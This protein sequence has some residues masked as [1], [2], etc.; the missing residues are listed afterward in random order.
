MRT[1]PPVIGL[2]V[3]GANT[4]AAVVDG[5]K[6][7]RI[8]SEPY[9]VW[10]DPEAMSGVIEDVVGRFGLDA[11]PVALTTT[12]EL[13]DVFASKREGVLHVLG[14]AER[15]L[16]GRRL[17]VMSTG[18]ELIAMEAA[19]AAPLA[20]AAANWMATALLVARSLPEAILVDCGG[21]T[22][23]VIPIA[24]GEVAARAH[25]DLERLLEGE[26]VYT[27]ALRTN[28]AAVLAQVP[29]GGRS[30]PVSSELFAVTAD[31]HLLRG[32]LTPEQCTCSF[33]DGRG[34]STDEV[35][36]RL[37]R[38]VCADPEQLGDRDLETI[39]AAVE[40]AQVD[41]IAAAL[42]RVAE[43]RQGEAA[44]VLAVGIGAF[45]ARAAAARC[46]LSVHEE[47][48]LPLAG[49]AGD[50]AA[51]VALSVLGRE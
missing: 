4:K 7:V 39:A 48:G 13:V 38:V 41:A 35:R 43:R 14:A 51:A 40:E 42:R 17:R 33:P 44:P 45:L 49:P 22:T 31:A 8:V 25:T 5:G 24:G 16:P 50:V 37:A 10:R 15:A 47:T 21:T 20:C 26:L 28:V 2:D 19:R 6:R 32:N 9:E 23:D 29:V 12:A 3:G 34:A 18:G 36:S 30:C 46:G 1:S 27:G 11:G